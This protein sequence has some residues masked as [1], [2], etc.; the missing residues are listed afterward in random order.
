MLAE[1]TAP[2]RK[3]ERATSVDFGSGRGLQSFT[4]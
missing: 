4:P 2:A 1:L 3:L